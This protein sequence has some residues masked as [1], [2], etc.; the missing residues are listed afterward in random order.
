MPEIGR[1][2]VHDHAGAPGGGTIAHS[3]TTGQGATD[4]HT[5]AILE[6]LLTTRGDTIIRDAAGPVRL[7]VGANTEV[8]TSDGTDPSWSAAGGGGALTREGGNTTEATTTSTSAVDLLTA[9]GLTIAVGEPFFAIASLRKTAGAGAQGIA[10]VT[11][12]ATEVRSG[13]IWSSGTD[14]IEQGYWILQVAARAATHLRGGV[15]FV[16]SGEGLIELASGLAT[17]DIP[18]VQ[19]TDV[20]LRGHVGS[21]S[22]T[23]GA[24]E[25]H[26]YSLAAS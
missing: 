19:I 12:N 3:A 22:I 7:A 24:D 26:V 13:V 4:H 9:T 15:L 25:L 21:A 6:S 17:A 14:R 11:L 10:G 23:M 5:A 8:I 20:I 18:N 2:Q 1:V 16:G